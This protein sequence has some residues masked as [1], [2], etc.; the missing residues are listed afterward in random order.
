MQLLNLFRVLGSALAIAALALAIGCSDGPAAP[1]GPAPTPAPTPTPTPTPTPSPAPVE[2]VT[3]ALIELNPQEISGQSQSVAT[4]TLTGPAPEGGALV[5]LLSTNRDVAKV[6]ASVLIPAGEKTGTVRVESSTV[7]DEVR[8]SIIA[9]YGGA[10]NG[11]TLTVGF[12]PLSAAFVVPTSCSLL[13]LGRLSCTFDARASKGRISAYRW[14]IRTTR[15]GLYEWETNGSTATPVGTT[16]AFFAGLGNPPGNPN[17]F[18]IQ[19]ELQ[20]VGRNGELSNVASRFVDV[21]AYR[22]CGYP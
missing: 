4:V 22:V 11:A 9:F 15:R 7:S 18:V 1:T 17:G 2:P 13:D 3:V 6:P 5:S 19:V 12:D 21:S 16:C 10:S 8:L 20:V 14:S